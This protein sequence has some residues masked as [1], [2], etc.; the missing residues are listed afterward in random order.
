MKA[1]STIARSKKRTRVG[2]ARSGERPGAR[3]T[4]R[5]LYI[6]VTVLAIV[7]FACFANSLANGFVFDDK[8]LILDN[9]LL[10]SL[11]N[12]PRLLTSSYRPLRDISHAFDF[13]LWGE[14][15]AGF[16]LTNVVIHLANT[17]L[18][19]TLIRRLAGDLGVAFVAA[20]VL[21]AH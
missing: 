5:Q 10:R 12:L 15:A 3:D 18:V 8:P 4:R 13:A 11:A 19:F 2:T 6:A 21:A 1:S 17:L 9:S 20:A 14:N 7:V 16:H